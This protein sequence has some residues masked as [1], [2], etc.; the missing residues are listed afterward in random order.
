[1]GHVARMGK[2]RNAH[3]ILVGKRERK[4][5]IGR[6]KCRQED[7]IKWGFKKQGIPPMN[8]LTSSW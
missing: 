1:M 2:T 7:N 5:P 3:N 6:L 8:I 4:T